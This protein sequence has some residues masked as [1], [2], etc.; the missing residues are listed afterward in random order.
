[1]VFRSVLLKVLFNRISACL[2]TNRRFFRPS[3]AGSLSIMTSSPFEKLGS[4][5]MMR[6]V[7]DG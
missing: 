5:V 6:V 4:S 3:L 7:D 1:M 2:D